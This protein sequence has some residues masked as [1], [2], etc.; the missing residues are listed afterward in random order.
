[1]HDKLVEK[2]LG[3]ML[4]ETLLA[5]SSFLSLTSSFLNKE[6]LSGC[7]LVVLVLVLPQYV[8]DPLIVLVDLFCVGAAPGKNRSPQWRWW[9]KPHSLVVFAPGL[10]Q[11]N[12]I[13]MGVSIPFVVHPVGGARRRLAPFEIQP[14][15]RVDGVLCGRRQMRW[16]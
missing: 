2:T 9:Q 14:T 1:M 11:S 7:C 8:H 3:G 15:G 10:I 16:R 6:A 4:V 13:E 5:T 12:V